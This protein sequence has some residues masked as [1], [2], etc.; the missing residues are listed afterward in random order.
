MFVNGV[1]PGKS[2]KT[3]FLSPGKSWN[4]AFASPGKQCFNVCTN[5]GLCFACSESAKIVYNVCHIIATLHCHL[6]Y[7]DIQTL[8]LFYVFMLILLEIF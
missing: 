5:P 4:L 7:D 2:L 3:R 1:Y 6:P 8:V